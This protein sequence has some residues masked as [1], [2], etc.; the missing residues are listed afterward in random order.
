MDSL[1]VGTIRNGAMG[2]MGAD[3]AQVWIRDTTIIEGDSGRDT[4]KFVVVVDNPVDSLGIVLYGQWIVPLLLSWI[5][6]M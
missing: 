3:V 1:A 6:I 5:Q 4:L 2:M